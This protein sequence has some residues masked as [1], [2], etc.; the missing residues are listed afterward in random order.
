MFWSKSSISAISLA[1]AVSA[2]ASKTAS[3][4]KAASKTATASKTANANS[5]SR[6]KSSASGAGTSSEADDPAVAL[7]LEALHLG[8]YRLAEGGDGEQQFAIE[9][10]FVDMRRQNGDSVKDLFDFRWK[11]V[12]GFASNSGLP[13]AQAVNSCASPVAPQLGSAVAES[14]A[15]SGTFN[16]ELQLGPDGAFAYAD[17]GPDNAVMDIK[18]GLTAAF[19]QGGEAIANLEGAKLPAAEQI[20]LTGAFDA[21]LNLNLNI[22]TLNA[23]LA[24][25]KDKLTVGADQGSYDVAVVTLLGSESSETKV[26]RCLISPGG[27][28]EIAEGELAKLLPLRGFYSRFAKFTVEKTAAGSVW[29]AAIA[30]DGAVNIANE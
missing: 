18:K 25:A 15:L 20:R 11:T 12:A 30:G 23:A 24:E 3:T 10:G 26:L 19:S 13:V 29:L 8:A 14:V 7:G 1:A 16:Q 9:Y 5:S 17:A 2:C 21:S 22:K 6:A 28:A 27:K 4:D